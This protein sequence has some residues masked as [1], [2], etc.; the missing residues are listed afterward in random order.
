MEYVTQE[1]FSKTESM[2]TTQMISNIVECKKLVTITT[3]IAIV[4]SYLLC[5]L[6]VFL[7][8]S[9]FLNA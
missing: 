2:Y 6:K 1:Y 8:L 5:N 3:Q 4:I 7:Y 9:I